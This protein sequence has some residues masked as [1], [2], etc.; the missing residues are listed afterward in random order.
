MMT[1]RRDKTG[2]SLIEMI[3]AI[4]ILAVLAGA[5]APLALQT[6]D[7]SRADTTISRQKIIYRAILGDPLAPGSG[8]LSDIGRL[9]GADL[10]ELTLRG[11]LPIYLIQAGGVG[12]GWR[13]PYLLEGVDIATGKPLDGWG[14]PMDFVNGRQIRSGGLDHDLTTAADNIVYPPNPIAA[15]NLNGNIVLSVLALDT[16]TAQAS[17]VP[18]GGQ[19]Q[20]YYA[21]DG[22]MQSTVLLS[23]SGSYTFSPLVQGIHAITITG[24]PDGAGPQ[25]PLA[26]TI[27][28]YCPGGGAVHQTVALR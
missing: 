5:M 21:R 22:A 19:A 25:L 4:A 23:A 27:T 20:M 28:L 3:V 9:P 2:F 11:A 15:N 18:A 7:R 6:I 13:G 12:M 16:S 17:Y 14:M 26:Q 24:D 8:F 1:D 10:S